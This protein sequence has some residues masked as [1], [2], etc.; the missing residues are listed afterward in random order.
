M[1]VFPVFSVNETDAHG[2]V[3]SFGNTLSSMP[4]STGETRQHQYAPGSLCGTRPV[5]SQFGM[6]KDGDFYS[7]SNYK[8][9]PFL[10]VVNH[11]PCSEPTEL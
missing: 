3:D 6:S 1:L 9:T 4:L 10:Q 8:T 11:P 2:K 5:L 7:Q